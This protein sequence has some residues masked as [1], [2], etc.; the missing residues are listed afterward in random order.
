LTPK[1]LKLLKKLK[2]N[3]KV[4]RGRRVFLLNFRVWFSES[5]MINFETKILILLLDSFLYLGIS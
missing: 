1:L 2:E 3:K 4:S 5:N